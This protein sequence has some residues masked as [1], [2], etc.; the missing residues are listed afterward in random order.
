V[1][2]EKSPVSGTHTHRQ[3]QTVKKVVF[4]FFLTISRPPKTSFDMTIP[5]VITNVKDNIK[6]GTRGGFL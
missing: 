3:N 1:F 4:Y 6:K 2:P 5:G